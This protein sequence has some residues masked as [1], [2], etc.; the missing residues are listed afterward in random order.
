MRS[1]FVVLVTLAIGFSGLAPGATLGSEQQDPGE[2][3][4][5]GMRT[6][7]DQAITPA[8]QTDA[9]ERTEI[10]SDADTA[11]LK[12][13]SVTTTTVMALVFRRRGRPAI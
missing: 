2:T 6:G 4:A 5:G 3:V 7:S 11:A 8:S 12:S 10:S 9:T 1:R 13:L